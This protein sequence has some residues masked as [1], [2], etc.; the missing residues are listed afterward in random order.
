MYHIKSLELYRS[1][2][3]SLTIIDNT[4]EAG[5]CK[6]LASPVFVQ[7]NNYFISQS[8]SDSMI[9]IEHF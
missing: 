6:F 2:V 4:G 1:S 5:E 3:L 8:E 9:H 7:S